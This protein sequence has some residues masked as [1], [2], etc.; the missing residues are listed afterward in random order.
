MLI[1]NGDKVLGVRPQLSQDTR[2][3]YWVH[4]VSIS[5]FYLSLALA[6]TLRTSTW[7]ACVLAWLYDG[8][9]SLQREFPCHACQLKLW[10]DLC[11]S[12][13]ATPMPN[14][15]AGALYIYVYHGRASI[16]SST[17]LR[18]GMSAVAVAVVV[19]VAA[20][21]SWPAWKTDV[22][23]ENALFAFNWKF[24]TWIVIYLF[25]LPLPLSRCCCQFGSVWFYFFANLRFFRELF[26]E[27]HTHK[28]RQR[29]RE[30]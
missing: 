21:A 22:Q 23:H 10:P 9:G 27:T 28:Q 12:S 18:W 26:L 14:P 24:F 13:R 4:S 20:T 15:P 19:D 5:I 17:R 3:F 6:R 30:R 16:F 11:S 2:H 25:S 7:R 8:S 29:E 1:N